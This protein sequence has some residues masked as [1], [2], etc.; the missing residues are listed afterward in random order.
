M[1]LVIV[2]SPSKAKTI[3]KYLGKNYVVVSSYGHVRGI[4][5]RKGA[6]ECDK[7][8]FIHYE[9]QQKSLKHINNILL[10]ARKAEKIYLATDPD[11][12]GEAISWHISQIIISDTK[13]IFDKILR[14]TFQEITKLAITKAILNPRNIDENLV[15]AQQTRQALDYLV[16]FGISPLLWVKLPGTVS[17]G[18]V[19]S[20][21]LRLICEREE[22][23]RKFIIEDYWTIN[24]NFNYKIPETSSSSTE[25]FNSILIEFNNQ[26]VTRILEE[27]EA[28]LILKEVNKCQFFVSNIDYKITRKNPSPPFTTSTMIQYASNYLGFTSKKTAKIAQELY[29]GIE[30]KG[31]RTGLITYMR[32]D[33]VH[34]S[35][36]AAFAALKL[37]EDQ[38]GKD[39]AM[40]SPRKFSNKKN[41]QEAHEAIRP[42]RLDLL[43]NSLKEYLNDDQYQLYNAI[44]RRLVASQMQPAVLNSTII[45]INAISSD[46]QKINNDSIAKFKTVGTIIDFPGYYIVM[47]DKNNEDQQNLPN[48]KLNDI[49]LPIDILIKK[50]QTK[51]PA[52]YNEASLVKKMEDIGIGRPSTYSSIINI[53][54]DRRYASLDNK[55]RFIPDIKGEGLNAMLT[56]F[57]DRYF[58]YDFTANLEH[59]LDLIAKG[60]NNYL[61]LLDEF[62]MNFSKDLESVSTISRNEIVSVIEKNL[63]NV[64][65][66]DNGKLCPKCSQDLHLKVTKFGWFIGCSGYPECDYSKNIEMTKNKENSEDNNNHNVILLKNI[67]TSS[68][69]VVQYPKYLSNYHQTNQPVYLQR[70][71]YGLYIRVGEMKDK[72]GKNIAIPKNINLN[73]IDSDLACELASLP[74]KLGKIDNLDVII[75]YGKFG[76]YILYN[77]KYYS[78]NE[79]ALKDEKYFWRISLEKAKE[80]I[81]KKITSKNVYKKY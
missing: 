39:Y 65:F 80:I 9:I 24:A 66:M 49:V 27:K 44:W 33:S 26:E 40:N 10:Y 22:E 72:R 1:Y 56:S 19:Q 32:T 45:I 53:L 36:E 73:D 18:R 52:R 71:P 35:S 55:K 67:S 16:G 5:S 20:P 78:I 13:E 68:D 31:E 76:P 81:S 43:P 61:N 21:A 11:R 2:E 58:S 64:L 60:E 59:K 37:I 29:E 57:F 48:I 8:F 62:W 7:N 28:N 15:Y 3:N 12:E 74:K 69:D 75:N 50:H 47:H 6:V 23:R 34:I 51:P 63:F 41:S 46:R 25:S 17:A 42:T 54:L 77:K 4:P 14:I 38:Y 79:S 70:G 30:I